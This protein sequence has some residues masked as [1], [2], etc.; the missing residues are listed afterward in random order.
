[1]QRFEIID[2]EQRTPEWHAARVGVMTGSRAADMLATRSDK[3]EAA[4]RRN[5][6]TQLALE[7]VIGRTSESDFQ[8]A[9]MKQG[10]E[11][12][13]E[14]IGV[15]EMITGRIVRQTGFLRCVDIAAGCSLDGHVNDFEGIVEIKCPIPA[16]HLESLRTQKV[17]SEYIPQVT[18]NMMV[19][20]ARWCDW[21]SYNPDFPDK[22]NTVLVRVI[23][24]DFGLMAY[25]RA[26][27]AFLLE[28]DAVEKEIRQLTEKALAHG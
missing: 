7:R 13:P 6:R 19:T 18:H 28:V 24:E 17:P 22:I 12:E 4:S 10:I 15:Y 5:L 16:T 26:L 11:R 9:A 20:G 3:K 14:A 27:E 2:C 23:R 8:S 1:V 25:R 21:M